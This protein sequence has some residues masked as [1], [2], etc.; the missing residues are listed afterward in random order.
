M[1]TRPARSRQKGPRGDSDSGAGNR[2]APRPY[3]AKV[4]CIQFYCSANLA[5]D[6]CEICR[7]NNAQEFAESILT[8]CGR[9]GALTIRSQDMKLL[10]D[11]KLLNIACFAI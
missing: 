7:R 8:G 3:W 11:M 5:L 10:K 4:Q 2:P 6:I 1:E 9:V